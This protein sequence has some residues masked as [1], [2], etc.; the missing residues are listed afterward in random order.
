MHGCVSCDPATI[1]II[2]RSNC[3]LFIQNDS[4]GAHAEVNHVNTRVVPLRKSEPCVAIGCRTNQDLS[5]L[6]KIAIWCSAPT[7][8]S[9]MSSRAGGWK[10]YRWQMNVLLWFLCRAD[11]VGTGRPRTPVSAA[12]AAKGLQ[13]EY[14][15][16][17]EDPVIR[18]SLCCSWAP[19]CSQNLYWKHLTLHGPAGRREGG[20]GGLRGRAELHNSS[21]TSLRLMVS[22]LKFIIIIIDY[23]LHM[24]VQM[25]CD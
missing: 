14:R 18:S 25:I 4:R 11:G 24:Y 10:V 12:P 7:A 19:T 22:F 15:P 20:S 13:E 16:A 23:T 5:S 1:S 3:S 21:V 6:Q 17:G 2:W 9:H 8:H